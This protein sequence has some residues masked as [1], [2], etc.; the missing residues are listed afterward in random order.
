MKIPVVSL[1]RPGCIAG[2]GIACAASGSVLAG[3]RGLVKVGDLLGPTWG[4]LDMLQGP[5]GLEWG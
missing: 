4:C 5:P 3:Q 2:N 1:M